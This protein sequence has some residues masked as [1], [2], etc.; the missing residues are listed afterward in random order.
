M[1]V[2]FPRDKDGRVDPE[3]GAISTKGKQIIHCKFEKEVYVAVGVAKTDNP[4]GGDDIG[5]RLPMF[6][7]TEKKIISIC[8]RDKLR[9]DQIRLIQNKEK[10]KVWVKSTREDGVKYYSNP[11][12]EIPDLGRKS[13]D[14]LRDK[15]EIR[16]IKDMKY[17]SDEKKEKIV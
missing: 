14:V 3:N 1:T 17:I 5:K 6:L 9:K 12:N 8:D 13:R 7:Y 11:I 4:K 16:T 10:C 15:Y 2:L